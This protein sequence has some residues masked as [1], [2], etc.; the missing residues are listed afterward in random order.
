MNNLSGRS[1]YV[2]EFFCLLCDCTFLHGHSGRVFVF[3]TFVLTS[4]AFRGLRE[5]S[6]RIIHVY[7]SFMRN[8]SDLLD[9]CLLKVFQGK[10]A[11]EFLDTRLAAS[12]KDLLRSWNCHQYMTSFRI[13]TPVSERTGGL[14]ACLRYV[15]VIWLPLLNYS[16]QALTMTF[17]SVQWYSEHI[18]PDWEKCQ[19]CG[20]SRLNCLQVTCL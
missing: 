6:C 3:L 11:G 13:A 8:E 7:Y 9:M 4:W 19:T 16:R 1:R 14:N 10:H 18:I 20:R 15:R 12:L 5:T 17:L 2:E